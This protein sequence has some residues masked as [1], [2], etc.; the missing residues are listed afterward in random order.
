MQK[1]CLIYNT[2]PRYREAEKGIDG[3]KALN[4]K[5]KKENIK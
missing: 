5:K 1:L 2:A 4:I 3:I